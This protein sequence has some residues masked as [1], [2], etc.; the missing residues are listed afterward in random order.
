MLS[1]G[2][3]HRGS[4]VRVDGWA[5]RS[6]PTRLAGNVCVTDQATDQLRTRTLYEDADGPPEQATL[7]RFRLGC[8]LRSCVP[9]ACARNKIAPV[10]AAPAQYDGSEAADAGTSEREMR[11]GAPD[12]R[13]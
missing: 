3:G 2:I 10:A 8:V 1:F 12:R 7:G 4:P 13:A 5:T 11:E 6:R 9:R